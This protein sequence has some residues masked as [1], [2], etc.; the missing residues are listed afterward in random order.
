M[1]RRLA[2]IL[3]A[4][5]V[6]YSRLMGDNEIGTF[7]RLK[8]LR[9]MLVQPYIEKHK[10][11][12]VKLMGDGL[13]AEFPSVI[14]AVQCAVDIQ[15]AMQTRNSNARDDQRVQLRI[16]VNLGDIIVEGSDI[17]GDGVNIAARLEALAD[18]G[19]V[20]ISGS[21]FDIADG[22]LDFKF[23]DTGFQSVKN[24]KK[25]VQT[26]NVD[27]L[28]LETSELVE[29][30][31]DIEKS[32][33]PSIAI[34]PFANMS[35]DPEQD[36]FSDGITEDL[37]TEISRFRELAVV[38][39]NSSF[40][41]KG[42][43]ESLREVGS[44]LNAQYIVEGSVR[45]AGQRVR[46]TAQL[47]DAEDDAH[48]WAERYD[49]ALE[50]IFEV[51]DDIVRCIASTLVGRL[52][53]ERLTKIKSLSNDQLRVYDL[54]LRG[55]EHFFNWSIEENRKARECLQAALDIEPGNAPVMA[56]LSEVLLRM[57]LNG[58]SNNADADRHSALE[59]AERADEIDEDDSRTQTSLGMAYLFNGDP[60]KA[61]HHFETAM[62]I[63]PND[64]RVIIY[65]SR[66]AVFDGDIEKA[67]DL[68]QQ[69]LILNPYGKYNWNL[70]LASFAARNYE[71]V[72]SLLDAIRNPPESVLALLAAS[73]AMAGKTDKAQ[74]IC[75]NFTKAAADLPG[76]KDLDK[77]SD[78]QG[79]YAQR[80]P[81]RNQVDFEHLITALRK[82]GLP[83]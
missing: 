54:F 73:Y 82:A 57:W 60:D 67:V 30:N 77:P 7:E 63:N 2:A 15:R 66:H 40:V 62:R 6:G 68:C 49:R 71:E 21:A 56:L 37:I 24:I 1:E 55:R 59:L 80:W 26:Y 27:L 44:K 33:R 34:L 4:D 35:G 47:I 18:P 70:G 5:V 39:R 12:I 50:D 51:Q 64:T 17:Y 8:E 14:E 38:S 46:V 3:A 16:G 10:G 48:V 29:R 42:K 20:C 75:Q 22:K 83:I 45:K 81:F 13:L 28:G 79:Y 74:E 76:M 53:A 11:R 23:V 25:K 31:G 32:I 41:F 43:S 19:G 72:I 65:Y 36:Y 61:K 58:W 9:K 78:W 69:A 52:E